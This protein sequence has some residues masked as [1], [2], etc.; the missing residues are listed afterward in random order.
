MV[1]KHEQLPQRMEQLVQDIRELEPLRETGEAVTKTG[2]VG[3][4]VGRK[5]ADC[6]IDMGPGELQA[7]PYHSQQVRAPGWQC[8]L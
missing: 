4:T 2:K 7:G 5:E 3:G 1:K 8:L 6:G